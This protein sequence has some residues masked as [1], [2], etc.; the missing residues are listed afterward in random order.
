MFYVRLN[1]VLPLP[2][3]CSLIFRFPNHLH[4]AKNEQV[5][6]GGERSSNRRGNSLEAF[7]HHVR[8]PFL[9]IVQGRNRSLSAEF[10]ESF[11]QHESA[12]KWQTI[13][14]SQQQWSSMNCYEIEVNQPIEKESYEADETLCDIKQSFLLSC[15]VKKK[16]KKRSEVRKSKKFS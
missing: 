11:H 8:A 16:Y 10:D 13:S 1:S 3:L 12:R 2:P 7:L 5:L 9:V 6:E 15:E 4:R 14:W